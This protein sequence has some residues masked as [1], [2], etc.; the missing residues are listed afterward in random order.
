MRRAIES[1]GSRATP[2]A[3]LAWLRM[4]PA[5]SLAEVRLTTWPGG[6]ERL[7]ATSDFHGRDVRW[8]EDG[9]A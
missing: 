8:V 9:R 5:A 1:A 7:L 2:D 3:P 6:S 4:E